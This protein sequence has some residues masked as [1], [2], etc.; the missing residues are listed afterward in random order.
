MRPYAALCD[1]AKCLLGHS[2]SLHGRIAML[3]LFCCIFALEFLFNP[4][5]DLEPD[6]IIRKPILHRIQ[7]YILHREILSTFHTRVDNRSICHFCIVF[8]PNCPFPFDNH[9]QNLIHLYSSPT[10]ITTPNGIPIQSP[11]S[12]LLTC[13]DRQMG[14]VKALSNECFTLWSNALIITES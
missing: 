3:R 11:M 4:Q 5:F 7:R 6:Y 1:T 12:P 10:P 8:T 9:H 14:Q 2:Y 13:E